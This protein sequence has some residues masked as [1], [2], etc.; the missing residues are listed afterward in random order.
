MNE[1]T[2]KTDLKTYLVDE[3]GLDDDLGNAD[4]IFGAGLLDSLEVL[5][6]LKFI[7]E[8]FETHFSTFEVSFDNFENIDKITTLVLSKR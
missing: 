2:I 3:C 7:E 1:E 4:P 8:K 5:N 6:I